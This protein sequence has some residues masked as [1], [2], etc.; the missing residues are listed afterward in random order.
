MTLMRIAR[1]LFPISVL[2]CLGSVAIMVAPGPKLSIEFTGGT[3]LELQLPTTATRADLDAALSSFNWPAEAPSESLSVSQTRT[4]SFFVRTA[5]LTPELHQQVI[6]HLTT[7]F[8]EL[9]ELQ[10]TT[11][12]PTV[13]ATLKRQALWAL[14]AASIAIIVYLALAFRTVPKE[15]S[16]WSFGLSAVAALLH[17]LLLTTGIFVILSHTTSFQMD[18]LFLSALLSIMGYSVMDTIVIFDRIRENL[19]IEGR[20]QRFEDVAQQSV[21]QTL[22][23]TMSTAVV[24]LIMLACLFLFGAET[25]RWFMLTLIIGTVIG[26]YSSFFIATPLIAYLRRER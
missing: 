19:L 12:G 23:R 22:S 16:P 15:L 13:G 20:R 8:P 25:I 3:L 24:T 21:I 4:G 5:T 2:L 10:F 1:F 17:D 26:T 6:A 11:I 7:S 14:L 18:T 9:K